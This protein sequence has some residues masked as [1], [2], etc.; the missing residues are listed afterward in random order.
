MIKIV[1]P[2]ADT[3][4]LW[5]EFAPM[6]AKFSFGH[7]VL[8]VGTNYVPSAHYNWVERWPSGALVLPTR[9]QAIAEIKD[10]LAELEKLFH[11]AIS[12]SCVLPQVD[13]AFFN[14]IRTMNREIVEFCVRRNYI[15]GFGVATSSGG[16]VV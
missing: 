8:Q 10:L 1:V 7:C 3:G 6:S 9:G 15:P 4:R 16:M 12:F 5:S 13:L 14:D 11:C 2:G